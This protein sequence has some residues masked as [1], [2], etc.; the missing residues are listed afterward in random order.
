[1]A[2]AINRR[3]ARRAWRPIWLSPDHARPIVLA[4]LQLFDCL[5]VNPVRDGM[6]LVAKEGAPLNRRDGTIVLSTT[7]GAHRELLLPPG[8][9]H[10][11]ARLVADRAGVRGTED[12]VA[13]LLA[14]LEVSGS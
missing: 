8:E 10:R 7:A 13:E 14:D 12:W 2:T 9:R 5:L 6:N 3:F 11:R 1:V 4:A